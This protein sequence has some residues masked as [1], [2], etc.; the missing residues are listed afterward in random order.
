MYRQSGLIILSGGQILSAETFS[1]YKLT[2][3][4]ASTCVF[5]DLQFFK[6]NL[7]IV[8]HIKSQKISFVD[9]SLVSHEQIRWLNVNC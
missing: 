5:V 1:C 6:F 3:N 7:L 2:I 8:F 4:D 9:G